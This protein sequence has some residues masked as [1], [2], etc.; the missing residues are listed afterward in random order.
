MSQSVAGP[1]SSPVV[2]NYSCQ[3]S[4]SHLNVVGP[5]LALSEAYGQL[6]GLTWGNS[7]LQLFTTWSEFE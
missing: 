6:H 2:V 4:G 5:V 1:G 7:L 3:I